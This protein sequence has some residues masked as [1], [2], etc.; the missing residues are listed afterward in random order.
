MRYA[1]LLTLILFFSPLWAQKPPFIVEDKDSSSYP[2]VQLFIRDKKQFPLERENF[3]IRESRGSETR[4]VLRPK[5]LRK[6]G[7]RPVHSVFLIQ[8]GTSLEENNFNTRFLQKVIQSS[9][10]EDHFSFIFFSDDLLVVEKDLDRQNAFSKARVPGSLGN[11]NTGAN[12]DLVFQKLNSIL[13]RE[14]YLSLLVADSEYKL[15]SGLRQG[16]STSGLPIQVIGK[17]NFSNLEL[18]R[19]YGG[20]FYDIDSTDLISKFLTDFEY[21]HKYAAEIRYDSP[22]QNDFW[23]EDVDF[24]RVDWESS[25]GGKFTYTYK[26]GIIKQLRFVLLS[27]EVFLPT[28]SFLLVLTLI[29]LLLLFR[30]ENVDFDEPGEEQRKFQARGEEREVYQR[31]YGDQF[32]SSPYAN[33]EGVHVSRSLPVNEL[34]FEAAEAYDLATLIQKE[35]RSP[36]KQVPIRKAE[37]TL[38]NGE[39]SDVVVSDPSVN[40]QHARIRKIKNRFVLYDLISDGGTYLNGKKILRPR[41]LYDFDEISLGKTVYVF[42]AR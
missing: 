25:R 22:F 34:E 16:L 38:G 19:I 36:G 42:R 3:L 11:Y 30:K 20:E 41:I 1:V 9:G 5:V 27:P 24:I 6:E 2:C 18:V 23:K 28:I 14:S 7:N 4:T 13:T 10:E 29:G 8:S 35:G 17:R 15:P 39:L 31:M 33:P 40:K 37:T 21:F 32:H 12:L 26:P